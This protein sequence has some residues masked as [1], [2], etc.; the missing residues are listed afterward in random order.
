[1]KFNTIAIVALFA[2]G[3]MQAH[4]LKTVG[5]HACDFLDEHGE[6]LD[7]SLNDNQMSKPIE[8]TMV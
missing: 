7:M 3:E 4:K 6:D 1:M 5:K 8:L 2:I